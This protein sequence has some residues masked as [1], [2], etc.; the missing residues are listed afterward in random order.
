MIEFVYEVID[1]TDDETFYHVGIFSSYTNAE[2]W[3]KSLDEPYSDCF[4]H[5]EDGQVLEVRKY[6]LNEVGWSYDGQ[7][8][9]KATISCYRLNI[10]GDPVWT[11]EI[12]E[13]SNE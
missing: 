7:L 11:V 9:I 5:T 4:E 13:V 8:V 1:R 12:E 3:I 6:K 10:E 2:A